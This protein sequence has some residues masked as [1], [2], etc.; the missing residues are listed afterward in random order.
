MEG[1]IKLHRQ[2][3]DSMTIQSLNAEQQAIAL[4]ILLRANHKPA[5]WVDPSRGSTVKVGVGQLITSRSKIANE[6]FKN[7]KNLTEQKTRTTLKRL[8]K[9][10]FLTITSTNWYTLITVV[11][12]GKWQGANQEVNQ[13]SNQDLTKTQPGLNQHPNHK[14]EVKNVKNEKN[15]KNIYTEEFEI[16]Y[17]SYP[18]K[19]A[20]K[21]AFKNW[22][23]R[24]KEKVNPDD[25]IKAAK[26]YA[27]ECERNKTEQK[28]IKHPS[29]F[30][31]SNK[32]FE[33][34]IEVSSN[35]VDFKPRDKE[36]D[37]RD[38]EIARNRWITNGGD[39]DEFIY[40]RGSS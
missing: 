27:I 4:Q 25:L 14:Q 37:Y 10:N 24:L 34:Y 31:G 16:F 20:K 2:W 32:G 8:E 29:T 12:Y 36:I 3:L 39:P 33:D 26:N 28:F 6:W 23:T 19:I 17:K 15:N 13:E 35:L 18:R 5:E 1:W 30:I 40:Q 11:N 38:E 21:Q 22:N 9:I 7:D